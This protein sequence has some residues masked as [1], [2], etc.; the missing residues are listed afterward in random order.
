MVVALHVL[1]NTDFL[2]QV[3]NQFALQPAEMD[4]NQ[5]LKF[6]MITILQTTMDAH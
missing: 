4:L 2:V 1:L 3:K 6:A 5:L